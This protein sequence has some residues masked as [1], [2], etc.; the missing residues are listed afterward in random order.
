MKIMDRLQ[1]QMPQNELASAGMMCTYCDLG[2]CIINPFDEEPH[3][4][5]CGIDA[6]SMNMVNL[7]LH[8]LKGLTDYGVGTSLPLSLDRMIYTHGA[9]ITVEDLVKAS[10]S[11]LE[12]SQTL[13]NQ[14]HSDQKKPRDIEVGMGVLQKDAVNLVTTVYAPDMIKQARSQKMRDLARE[15]TARGINLVG[16]L[17]EGAEAAS[18][19]GIPFLGGIDVLEEAGDMIDYVY[20][21]GDV[22]AACETAIENFSKR[23][24]ASFRKVTPRRVAVGYP[25]DSDALTRAVDSGL[26]TGVVA[27]MGCASGKS[28]WDLDAIAHQ[29]VSQKFM[30]LN[31]TCDLLEHPD[32]QCTLM[33]EFQF[34][35]VIN[36]GCCEP[37]KLLGM[38]A[39]TVLMPR[40][41]DPRMLTAAFAL[42]SQDIPVVLG[43]MP[44]VTPS[45]RN[46]LADVGIRV[47]KDSAKVVDVL[48]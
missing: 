35:C 33:S 31:L 13:V 48:R 38:K 28:T 32:H 27:I 23:D 10:A 43:T 2:P 45:V 36:A 17:C 6:E 5:A 22:T 42:A 30:V 47:E 40:W 29:L 16:A 46:Q 19:F 34:P 18:T 20:Q 9:G 12:P 14:W 25:V 4:G 11:I 37:A 3:A 1:A 21:G 39:L 7:G 15:R 44:F 41:R 8:V 24:Q 26:I